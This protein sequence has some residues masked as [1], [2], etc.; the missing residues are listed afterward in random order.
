MHWFSAKLCFGSDQSPS[1]IYLSYFPREAGSN[2]LPGVTGFS[3][4]SCEALA[5]GCWEFSLFTH[6]NSQSSSPRGS[7]SP[8]PARAES[9]DVVSDQLLGSTVFIVVHRNRSQEE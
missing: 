7:P 4:C 2:S 6:F 9:S 5:G 1:I 3:R 8:P